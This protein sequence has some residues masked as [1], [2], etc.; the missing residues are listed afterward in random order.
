MCR[1]VRHSTVAAVLAILALALPASAGANGSNAFSGH[2]PIAAGDITG[3]DVEGF[4]TQPAEPL[5]ITGSG[6]CRIP[7]AGGGE[8]HNVM[9][10]SAWFAVTGTGRSM[11]AETFQDGELIDTMIAVYT[12]STLSNLVAR[13]CADDYD[14]GGTQGVFDDDD[15]TDL[16]TFP[17]T[18]GTTYLIQIGRYCGSP[19]TLLADCDDRLPG[20]HAGFS[21]GPA[22]NDA[23]A[24]AR[25]I[26]LETATAAG[27]AHGTLESGEDHMCGTASYE[28]TAWFSVNVPYTGRL[29]VAAPGKGTVQTYVSIFRPDGSEVACGQAATGGDV[30]AGNYLIQ[31]G[32]VAGYT[33]DFSVTP[34]F[35]RNL[36]EDGDHVNIPA[37]CAPT[38]P[39]I[40]GPEIP[41]NGID[42]D[43]QYG[44]LIDTDLD[45]VPDALDRCPRRDARARDADH[46]GC[47]DPVKL[48]AQPKWRA[49]RA[50]NGIVVHSLR[51][52][53]PKKA[54]V[55]VRCS[56]HQC[57]G[58]ARAGRHGARVDAMRN[59]A[60]PNGTVVTID[61]TKRGF[62]GRYFRYHVGGNNLHIMKS[63]CLA[64][65]TRGKVKC[66]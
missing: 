51:V 29:D 45:T 40:P 5:T 52:K 16:L 15:G 62:Y 13:D 47:L 20:T 48:D 36:D 9:Y 44:D 35:K 12:G 53:A 46:D 61:V 34:S 39:A 2:T 4:D 63:G 60:L 42:D 33:Q 55:F 17:T 25:P 8:S 37:D 1:D 22:A 58:R 32:T 49:A 3:V 7:L 10:Q 18:S 64:P 21:I 24:T 50:T 38:N 19:G 66:P 26:P 43:C 14:D 59:E 57:H 56:N 23:R 41:N 11:T 6:Y 31:I 65:G 54:K 27:N 30:T 28:A